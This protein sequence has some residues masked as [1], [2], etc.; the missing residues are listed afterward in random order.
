M[1]S[2]ETLV[3]VT[4]TV[5]D[6]RRLIGGLEDMDMDQRIIPEVFIPVSHKEIIN[7][8]QSYSK[9][10]CFIV[11]KRNGKSCIINFL[12]KE[13]RIG[14]TNEKFSRKVA[15]RILARV[16]LHAIISMDA[17]KGSCGLDITPFVL[18]LITADH[19]DS[20]ACPPSIL[21]DLP[22]YA[23]DW[24]Q[25]QEDFSLRK[26]V[27]WFSSFDDDES[28]DEEMGDCIGEY[29]EQGQHDGQNYFFAD[30]LDYDECF[31]SLERPSSYFNA[32]PM[33]FSEMREDYRQSRSLLSEQVKQT[34]KN[35][36]TI[37]CGKQLPE[38][39]TYSEFKDNVERCIYCYQRKNGAKKD[40]SKEL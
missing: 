23:G 1:R 32:V 4:E 27:R 31:V 37:D 22:L 9:M 15:Q 13:F 29:F 26:P 17:S 12:T 18:D 19:V 38:F 28:F 3:S 2:I 16:Q 10:R 6:Q 11:S 14:L 36:H 35:L 39:A 33:R 40:N 20:F 24:S 8:F 34:L 25:S 5:T 7:T 21:L 30:D